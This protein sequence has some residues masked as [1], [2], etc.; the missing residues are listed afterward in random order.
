MVL[1]RLSRVFVGVSL[2]IELVVVFFMMMV[3][4]LELYG[5]GYGSV[6]F[7]IFF[8]IVKYGDI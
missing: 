4:V 8:V 5:V 1:G 6:I 7:C 3:L 2:R